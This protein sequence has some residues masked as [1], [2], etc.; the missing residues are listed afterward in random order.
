MNK[1][2]HFFIC[3]CQ[4][5]FSSHSY[6]FFS[7]PRTYQH[8]DSQT[9][10]PRLP[11]EPLTLSNKTLTESKYWETFHFS[12]SYVCLNN[13]SG[14]SLEMM[15]LFSISNSIGSYDKV[16]IQSFCKLCLP[17]MLGLQ[18][19]K[20]TGIGMLAGNSVYFGSFGPKASEEHQIIKTIVFSRLGKNWFT[21]QPSCE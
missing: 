4:D 7:P 21:L 6:L 9:S 18:L 3:I 19:P 16:F 13:E 10:I 20:Y 11:A 15:E 17:D 8:F 2:R 12:P 5:C 1:S 14:C